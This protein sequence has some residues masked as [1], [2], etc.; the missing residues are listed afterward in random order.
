M[1]RC[2]RRMKGGEALGALAS[3]NYRFPYRAR[4]SSFGVYYAEPYGGKAYINSA[5]TALRRSFVPICST[6]LAQP[7]GVDRVAKR[8]RGIV[9][10]ATL[11]S[12]ALRVSFS[13][14]IL[15]PSRID[16]CPALRRSIKS[17][18]SSSPSVFTSPHSFPAPHRRLLFP[19]DVEAPR[20]TA[21][22]SLRNASINLQKAAQRKQFKATTMKCAR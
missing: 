2:G 6:R 21:R 12:F 16:L 13:L 17:L 1:R 18:F 7:R 8:R 4:S 14:S 5:L 10:G 22:A 9:S 19:P 15:L 3:G 20:K 11:L